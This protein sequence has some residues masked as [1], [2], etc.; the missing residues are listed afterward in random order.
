MREKLD[1]LVDRVVQI[2]YYDGSNTIS[3][4]IKILGMDRYHLW[5][6]DIVAG[7]DGLI[8]ELILI[9]KRIVGYMIVKDDCIEQMKKNYQPI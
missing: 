3:F 7:S 9:K 4:L 6:E 1:T 5:G 2:N 8:E